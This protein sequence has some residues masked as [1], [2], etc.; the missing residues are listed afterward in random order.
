MSR[1]SKITPKQINYIHYLFFNA[2]D[3]VSEFLKK[4][5]ETTPILEKGYNEDAQDII[6][7]VQD[8]DALQLDLIFKKLT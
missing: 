1:S 8:D 3:N 4:Y 7:A 6:S 5:P 2:D